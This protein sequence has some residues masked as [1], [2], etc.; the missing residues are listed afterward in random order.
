MRKSLVATLF[1]TLFTAPAAHPPSLVSPVDLVLRH[2]TIYTADPAHPTAVAIAVT[3]GT[4]VYVGTDAGVAAYVGPATKTLDL[5]GRYVYPGFVDAHAHFPAIGA[6]ELTLNLEGTKSKQEFLDRVAAA[7]RQKKPGEWVTGR[8]WIETFWVPQAF[9]TRED[10]DRIA[11]NN[12][13]WLGRADGHASVANSAALRLAKVTGATPNPAGGHINLDRDGQ[14]TGM[15]IDHAQAIIERLVPPLTEAQLDTS[16][17]LADRRE[18]SLGWTQVQDAHGSWAEVERM[19]KLFRAGSLHIRL[20]KSIDG[21]GPGADRLIAQ[22]PG[23]PELNDHL[24]T[25]I[26]KLTMDGALGSRGAALLQ[27]YSDDPGNTGLI[28]TD[29]I[30]DRALLER[31][32]RAGIQVETHAIGDRANRIILDMYAAAMKA[33]PPAERKIANPRWRVEH[34]QIVAPVDMPRFK[35]LGLIASMQASHAIGDLFFAEGRLGIQRLKGAYAWQSFWKLGVPVAGGTD[36]PVERGE[37]MIEFYAAVA[38]KSLDGR[39]GPANVWHPEER[40]SRPQALKM[41]TWFPAYAAFEEERHGSIVVGKAA[42]FTILDHDIMTI[43]EAQIPATKNV[44]T[45]I[46]GEVVFPAR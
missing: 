16:Y 9:P 35:Q 1:G 11:P 33:V 4:I 17:I 25:R 40:L 24:Q 7:V 28:T 45:I 37:P 41:F 39:S 31:A 8:G 13:L 14:P 34:A 26:I 5:Q 15:L 29:T 36:A 22:G 23:A 20:Y 43:P 42:D 44:M 27:P 21:P 30:A 46:G 38:R 32:L 19:R 6:R 2:A 18:L 10:L 3:H 12:P